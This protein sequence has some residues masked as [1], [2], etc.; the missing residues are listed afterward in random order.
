MTGMYQPSLALENRAYQARLGA[1]VRQPS[2]ALEPRAEET[3]LGMGL[4]A[5][6]S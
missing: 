1:R 2:L 4:K 3:S 5:G 6:M